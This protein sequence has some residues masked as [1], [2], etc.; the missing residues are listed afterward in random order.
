MS[1]SQMKQCLI[2]WHPNWRKSTIDKWNNQQILAI[3]TKE[4]SKR[5]KVQNNY[6]QLSF[7]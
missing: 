7:F 5:P 4:L 6:K 1:I 2:Q 3:Y